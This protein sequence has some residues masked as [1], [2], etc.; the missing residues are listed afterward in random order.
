[1]LWAVAVVFTLTTTGL[2]LTTIAQTNGAAVQS[3]GESQSGQQAAPTFESGMTPSTSPGQQPPEQTPAP[4]ALSGGPAPVPP[5]APSAPSF[6]S[7]LTP[8]APSGQQPAPGTATDGT[9]PAQ[10]ATPPAPKLETGIRRRGNQ[11][12]RQVNRWRRKLE[13]GTTPPGQPAPP[14]GQ[15][16][17]PKLESGMPS[18]AAPP[19]AGPVT[20]PPSAAPTAEQPEGAPPPAARAREHRR[21]PSQPAAAGLPAAV[22]GPAGRGL[23]ARPAPAAAVPTMGGGVVAAVQIVGTQRIEPDTVRSY[24]QI[25]PGD[26][27]E[28]G[29]ARR[30]PK[31]A[32]CDRSVRRR[33]FEPGRKC[34]G[35]QGRRKPDHQPHRL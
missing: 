8:P 25:Q 1:M 15:P 16:P 33:Q 17:A 4:G 32:V 31:G 12:R 29:K 19:G 21:P 2:S 10:P 9:Q 14:T 18:P 30:V 27:S 24:L 26:A 5:A 35:R 28:F 3:A 13:S 20:V 23:A 7:G 6:G 11:R 34:A 22:P